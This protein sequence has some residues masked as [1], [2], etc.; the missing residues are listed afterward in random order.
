MLL[1]QNIIRAKR[2]GGALSLE[3]IQA[4]V[5]GLSAP[6]A[7]AQ[8]S[9]SQVAA[10]AMATVLRGMNTA[11]TVALTRA[12]T[13]S[14]E[15]LNWAQAAFHGPVL[16]KHST[17]GVG[18]KVSLMLAP[19][20]A[21]CGAVVPMISGRGLGH[22]GG[23]LDKLQALP[24]YRIHLAHN[25]LTQ[26][27]KSVGCAI[28][29]ASAQLA[30]ADQRLYA[31]RDVTATVESV[32]L[33]TASILSKKLAAGLQGLVFDVKVGSGAFAATAKEAQTLAHSLVNVGTGAGLPARAL[34]TDMNQ[35]LGHTAGNALEVQEAVQFLT[36]TDQEPRLLQVTLA[37]C[38]ELLHLG[39]LAA[40]LEAALTQATQT[41]SSGAAAE[42]FARMVA[43]QG[44]PVDV[45]QAAQLPAAPVQVAVPALR[46]GFIV[47]QDVRAIGQTIVALGGGRSRPADTIDPRVGLSATLPLGQHVAAGQALAVVHAA[48][49]TGAQQA[50]Q[51]L[52]AAITLGDLAP[53]PA[54][55]VQTLKLH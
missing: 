26:Q 16:D 1:P 48:D 39:G 29:G 30:P 34:I 11:E 36:G 12:M 31:I 53:T 25:A 22:T 47:Q 13:H 54:P 35:V 9:D 6:N 3:Q 4:F 23:T 45:L 20:L 10:L 40:T 50:V 28:V 24:G 41:L 46:S 37:L 51:A 21:A 33:I 43:A 5:Q 32:P 2:D 27:L 15:V 17:G 42:R 44:G 19:M 38:A 55:L 14:G 52:Q 8:W 18:D 7:Q 49:A